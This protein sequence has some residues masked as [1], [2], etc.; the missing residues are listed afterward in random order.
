MKRVMKRH[1]D[2]IR[3][4]S[5]G[6][7]AAALLACAGCSDDIIDN[8]N[9]ITTT[10]SDCLAF[11]TYLTSENTPSA[12]RSAVSNLGI[13]EERWDVQ[14]ESQKNGTATRAS[15]TNHLSG[16]AGVIGYQYDD[17]NAKTPIAGAGNGNNIEFTFDGD[18]LFSTNT[19]ILWK[20]IG[21]KHLDIYAYAP[22]DMAATDN[23]SL[24]YTAAL[25]VITYTVPDKM[26]DQKDLLVAKWTGNTD[27]YNGKTIPL[28]FDHAL[29]AIH[30]KVGFDCKV[31]SVEFQNVYSKG[32][33]SF[34]DENWEVDESL[35]ASYKI[36]IPD[37]DNS[38]AA[39]ESLL[40]KDDYLILMPQTLPEE[41]TIVFTCEDK[42][43]TT[44]IGG[45]TWEP[46]KLITYTFYRGKAPGTIYFDLAAADV[47]I[48]GETYSGAVYKDGK[49]EDVTGEYSK[50]QYYYVYQSTEANRDEIWK[51]GVCTPPIYEAVKSPDGT[52]SWCE[53]ITNNTDV[54]QVIEAWDKNHNT[55]VEDVKRTAT[56]NKIS[57]TGNVNC[58]LTIDNI[59]S[60]Y[61][62]ATPQARRG[63]GLFFEPTGSNAELTVHIAGD[64]RLGAVHYYNKTPGNQIIF[65]GS[66]SLTVA[67]VDGVTREGSDD[68]DNMVG[69]NSGEIG[70]WNN[71]WSSAIGGT[72]DNQHEE[73][74]G[75]VINS[76]IIFAG[77]TKAENC[78]AI[79]GGG[80]AHGDV[81]INGGTVTAVATTTGTAIGGGIGF[82][83]QG[84]TGTVTIMG[85]NVYAYNHANRWDIPSSAIGGAGSKKS[86][87]SQ[88]TV[89][90]SGGYVSADVSKITDW[91]LT[92]EAE[93]LFGM[94]PSALRA[95]AYRHKIP[96]KRE[97]GRTYYSKSHLDELRRT[98]LV[99]DERYYTVEQVRQIYGLSSANI[100]HIVKVK[101]IEKVKVGVKNLLLRSDV[102]RVMAERNQQP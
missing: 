47:K 51:N 93:E 83:V 88:G 100:S 43:Y 57:I 74:Y 56:N 17:E 37:D 13:V 21:K 12:T 6:A 101:H 23:M 69:V 72:D 38:F 81:T 15:L 35:S 86:Y 70:Y 66:G 4:W 16:E 25:P 40:H 63:A 99:N 33:Y 18:K 8:G 53:F 97:Y 91:L 49:K 55:L 78:T 95:Y 31:K 71:H 14:L 1:T 29:T 85:G 45:L 75:I 65:E 80:N 50:G 7:A 9:G 41:A 77:T 5:L 44:N 39:G 11:T 24:D 19:T 52:T 58:Y 90:I 34:E 73:A 59:Y 36:D 27:E 67:D 84:G 10:P 96:T 20:S 2:I 46:G 64:N 92:E 26:D 87:G 102:E 68:I 82:N 32:T 22:Y 89:N 54:D 30:F 48:D 62:Y 42:T 3:Q 28:A 98:D 61:Q 76:G 94:K 60:T 79:G